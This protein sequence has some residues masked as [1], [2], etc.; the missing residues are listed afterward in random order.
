[1]DSY[2]NSYILGNLAMAGDEGPDDVVA[3]AFSRLA[4]GGGGDVDGGQGGCA[5]GCLT[6]SEIGGFTG[7][8]SLT[9][10]LPLVPK[11]KE[12]SSEESSEMIRLMRLPTFS[13]LRGFLF[14]TTLVLTLSLISSGL[15]SDS[16]SSVLP[17]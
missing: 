6:G 4:D 11:S 16:S 12:E 3:I 5:L 1:M 2:F 7:S 14:F 15:L 9:G 10:S 13:N 8:W 17:I